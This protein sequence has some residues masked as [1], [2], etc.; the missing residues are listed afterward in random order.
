MGEELKR[1]DVWSLQMV[2]DGRRAKALLLNNIVINTVCVIVNKHNYNDV[3]S[4]TITIKELQS[5]YEI[6]F[7]DI[8]YN[9]KDKRLRLM[10]P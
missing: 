6:I 8:V 7:F 10:N 4:R 1:Y 2:C 3:T 9:K 5:V